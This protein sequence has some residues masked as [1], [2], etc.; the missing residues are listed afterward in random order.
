M[1]NMNTLDM[2]DDVAPYLL[3]EV[4]LLRGV[5]YTEGVRVVVLHR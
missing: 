4:E 5:E 1:K 2:N 3:A